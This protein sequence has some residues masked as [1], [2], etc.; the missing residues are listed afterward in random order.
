MSVFV[1][2][3]GLERAG[4]DLA[5]GERHGLL[6]ERLMREL[7]FDRQLPGAVRHDVDEQLTAVHIL[8]K[9]RHC[10]VKH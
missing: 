2:E 1:V 10:G 9:F 3:R 6:L 4:G 8:E 7:G 5:D